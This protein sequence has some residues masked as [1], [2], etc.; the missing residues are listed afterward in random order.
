MEV[1]SSVWEVLG[2]VLELIFCFRCMFV[3]VSRVSKS[4]SLAC[5][6]NLCLSISNNGLCVCRGQR[7]NI[8]LKLQVSDF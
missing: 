4:V 1:F 7:Y 6:S 8:R 5:V 3:G 2:F